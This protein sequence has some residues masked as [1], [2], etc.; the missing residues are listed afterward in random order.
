MSI[1]N[2]IR[3]INRINAFVAELKLKYADRPASAELHRLSEALQTLEEYLSNLDQLQPNYT[4]NE[5]D[6]HM[7]A[8]NL[9][10]DILKDELEKTDYHQLRKGIRV[11]KTILKFH[12]TKYSS[13]EYVVIWIYELLYFI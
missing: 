6:K 12:P 3:V 11:L 5:I 4:T 1:Q 8:I 7:V 9:N 2:K 10:I 13:V